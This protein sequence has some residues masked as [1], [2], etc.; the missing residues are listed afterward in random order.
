MPLSL[1]SCELGAHHG[2]P[3]LKC[4]V[5]PVDKL[6]DE[7]IEQGLVC[8][9]DHYHHSFFAGSRRLH[10]S[11][12]SCRRTPIQLKRQQIHHD[13]TAY[14][15]CRRLCSLQPQP[16]SSLTTRAGPALFSAGLPRSRTRPTSDVCR[17]RPRHRNARIAHQEGSGHRRW[18]HYARWESAL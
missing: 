5:A 17:A 16:P 10:A 14:L 7:A 15:H 8:Y 9:H 1:C 18:L 4:A 2:I 3:V 12:D 11:V 13:N 6:P